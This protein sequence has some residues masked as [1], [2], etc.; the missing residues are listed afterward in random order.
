MK[1]QLHYI[2]MDLGGPNEGDSE[3][4]LELWAVTGIWKLEEFLAKY[5]A[6]EAYLEEHA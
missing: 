6:F 4:M 1:G 3:R 2:T 5:A